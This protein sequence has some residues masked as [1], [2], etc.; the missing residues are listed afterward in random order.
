MGTTGGFGG[1]GLKLL[2]SFSMVFQKT[3]SPAFSTSG[4]GRVLGDVT[5]CLKSTASSPVN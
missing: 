3:V 2:V 5:G 4:L 1:K